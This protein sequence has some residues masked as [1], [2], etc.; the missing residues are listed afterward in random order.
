MQTEPEAQFQLARSLVLHLH[1]A[2]LIA[3]NGEIYTAQTERQ[4]V[5][6]TPYYRNVQQI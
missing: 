6:H 4:A 1:G 5:T 2:P 3:T